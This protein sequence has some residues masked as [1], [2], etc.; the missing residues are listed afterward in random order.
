[1]KKIILIL[2]LLLMVMVSVADSRMS[3]VTMGG[4]G[5]VPAGASC[6][7]QS[8]QSCTV[9][10]DDTTEVPNGTYGG[11]GDYYPS[12]N[13]NLCQIDV[14]IVTAPTYDSMTVYVF[15]MS[16]T[17]LGTEV[18]HTE[19]KA[20]GDISSGGWNTFS[21]TGDCNIVTGGTTKYG[22]VATTGASYEIGDKTVSSGCTTQG[23]LGIW[24][25]DKA[26]T[27]NYMGD[28]DILFKVYGK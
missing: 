27:N 13:M 19:T 14:W 16:G 4:A 7:Y 22:I 10:T 25:S 2:F 9:A 15:E 23:G 24:G 8:G 17:S 26:I 21:I 20:Y 5:T 12:S 18:C 1:M 28:Y 6:S 3:C 11:Q